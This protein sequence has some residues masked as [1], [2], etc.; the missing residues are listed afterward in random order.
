MTAVATAGRANRDDGF[1]NATGAA[2]T[3]LIWTGRTPYSGPAPKTD[4]DA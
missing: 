3:G 4:D 1:V 2:K